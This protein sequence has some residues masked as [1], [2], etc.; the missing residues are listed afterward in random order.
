MLLNEFGPLHEI[1]LP[2]CLDKVVAHSMDVVDNH[3]LDVLL[4]HP[5]CEIEKDLI[6]VLDVFAEL[7]D[8]VVPHSHFRHGRLMLNEEVFLHFVE[9]LLIQVLASDDEEGLAPE[10]PLLLGENRVQEELNSELGLA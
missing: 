1:N 6:V 7:H 2:I 8:D 9:A 4:L 5:L 3:E 10:A